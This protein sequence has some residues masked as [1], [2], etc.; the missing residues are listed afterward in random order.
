M[1]LGLDLLSFNEAV[2][3]SCVILSLTL[4][5]IRVWKE[6]ET[7][8]LACTESCGNAVLGMLTGHCKT[9]HDASPQ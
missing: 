6:K 5:I 2:N 7:R 8:Q 4:E 9:I 1:P 3:G